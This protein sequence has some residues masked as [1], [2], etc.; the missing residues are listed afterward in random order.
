M[1]YSR[2]R[3]KVTALYKQLDKNHVTYI[4]T[5]FT[6]HAMIYSYTPTYTHSIATG[7]HGLPRPVERPVRRDSATL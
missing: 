3:V 5:H 1:R 4:L 7:M 6:I 2:T